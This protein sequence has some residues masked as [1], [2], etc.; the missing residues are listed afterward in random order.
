VSRLILLL[1]LAVCASAQNIRYDA[2][3]H[4]WLLRTQASS[5]AMGVSPEG[6]LQHLYWGGPLWRIEDIPAAA[7]KRDISSFDPHQ[8]LE[9]EEYPGWGGPRFDEPALKI[10]RAD[11]DRDLVLRYVSQQVKADVLAITLKDIH[12]DIEVELDYRVRA[13][14]IGRKAVIRNR[15]KQAITLESAQSAA[16]YLPAGV[17]YRLSY[18]SGRWAAETQ[19]N[20]EPI[21]EGIKVLESRTGHTGHNINPW[22]AIDEGS[23]DETSGRVW[24][25]ALAWS[26][27]WRISVEQTPYQQVRVTGG[28]NPFDFAYHL[29]P[30]ESL[31]TPLFYAGY[32]EHGFGEASRLL[33]DLERTDIEPGGLKA[34]P[35][36]VL[37]NSWEATE[38]NVDEAGQT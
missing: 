31:E 2:G 21:Q 20:R 1:L 34:R 10:T 5:Y 19:L 18:L 3:R 23:A 27:N 6:E 26:G 22:F 35:R 8:M 32:S 36:P 25:G 29:A 14:T 38:F 13:A 16:W 7:R 12:D 24:F 4:I 37:Y 33:H 15:S 9:N 28:F 30:G 17:G 11:G